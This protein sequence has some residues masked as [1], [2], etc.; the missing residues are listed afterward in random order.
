LL[1][2]IKCYTSQSETYFSLKTTAVPDSLPHVEHQPP[3]AIKITRPTAN[4]AN[5]ITAP[6]SLPSLLPNP[7]LAFVVALALE[8]AVVVG[9]LVPVSVAMP[10]RLVADPLAPMLVGDLRP[11][12]V[13]MP[14]NEL[15]DV[16]EAELIVERSLPVVDEDEEE[17]EEE[18]PGAM[19][20]MT[21]PWR[22]S[23]A[24]AF[25]TFCAAAA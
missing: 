1:V 11:V 22:E 12:S 15:P 5:P 17:E 9:T 14:V 8:L 13:A 10:V 6:A 21:P 24:D 3:H 18:E 23:G 19:L 4:T 2:G 16:V 20:V 25:E 7:A